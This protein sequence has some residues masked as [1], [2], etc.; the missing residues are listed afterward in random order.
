SKKSTPTDDLA[1]AKGAVLADT[2]A[3][4]GYTAQPHKDGTGPSEQARTDFASCLKTDATIFDTNGRQEADGPD[5]TNDQGDDIDNSV[6]VYEKKGEID[7]RYDLLTKPA[8]E[9]CIGKL[10]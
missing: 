4:P 1:L 8:A 3:P 6:S 10:F 5:F 9:E 7:T 2:D